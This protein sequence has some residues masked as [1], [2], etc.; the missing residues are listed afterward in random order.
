MFSS[1]ETNVAEG[2]TTWCLA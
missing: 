1:S 2:K